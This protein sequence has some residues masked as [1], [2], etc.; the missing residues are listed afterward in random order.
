M[1]E[2]FG[3]SEP[4]APSPLCSVRG[5]SSALPARHYAVK[6]VSFARDTEKTVQVVSHSRRSPRTSTRQMAGRARAV[7]TLFALRCVLLSA[8]YGA[9]AEAGYVPG[10][11]V[12]GG[13]G[14]AARPPSLPPPLPPAPPLPPTCKE[15]RFRAVER[16]HLLSH[17]TPSPTYA[18]TYRVDECWAV[19]LGD[20]AAAAAAA[21]AVPVWCVWR[22]AGHGGG[23]DGGAAARQGP[24]GHSFSW[25]LNDSTLTSL[26]SSQK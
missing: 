21:A 19:F 17:R 15:I 10:Q 24:H 12:R 13:A 3:I 16:R 5:R 25:H 20:D 1:F 8:V 9:L 18:D 14:S 26:A 7:V 23:A 22:A 6:G 4:A 11:S 2:G